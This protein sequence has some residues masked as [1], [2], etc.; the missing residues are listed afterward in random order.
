MNRGGAIAARTHSEMTYVSRDRGET[1][2]VAP[3]SGA[4]DRSRW[5][6]REFGEVRDD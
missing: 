5:D 1:C 6:P 2:G 3:D 4:W